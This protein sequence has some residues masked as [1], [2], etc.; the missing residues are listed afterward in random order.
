MN[1]KELTLKIKQE[2]LKNGFDLFGAT[3]ASKN[4]S[5]KLDE[6]L[7]G[8]YHASMQWI[9]NRKDERND[10]IKQTTSNATKERKKEIK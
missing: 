3:S 2:A 4:N 8:G 10:I 6:W 7:S 1:K 5:N 9:E